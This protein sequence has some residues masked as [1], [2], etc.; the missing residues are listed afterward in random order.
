MRKEYLNHQ[1]GLGV[2]TDCDDSVLEVSPDINQIEIC[3]GLD[4]NCDGLIDNDATDLATWYLDNDDDGY[5]VTTTTI[6]QCS[7]P[8]G[9]VLNADDCDDNDSTVY[10]FCRIRQYRKLYER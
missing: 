7:L 10:W 5:G 8:E 1:R 2:G 4:N 6:I 9:Y 3:D